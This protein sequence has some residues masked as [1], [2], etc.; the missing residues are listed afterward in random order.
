[1]RKWGEVIESNLFT[2][3][4]KFPRPTLQVAV[5]SAA[6]WAALHSGTKN[7]AAGPPHQDSATWGLNDGRSAVM[8]HDGCFSGNSACP[9]GCFFFRP[10]HSVTAP[11]PA[12]PNSSS[13]RNMTGQPAN[14]ARKSRRNERSP[15]FEVS[16]TGGESLPPVS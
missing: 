5:L 2:R 13:P 14:R 11:G 8:D 3:L 10:G 15:V 1:M 12:G 6:V 16:G 9:Y 7:P 4:Q